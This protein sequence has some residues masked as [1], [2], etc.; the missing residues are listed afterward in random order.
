MY[1]SKIT[2]LCDERMTKFTNRC[3][4]RERLNSRLW[5]CW[6]RANKNIFSRRLKAASVELKLRTGSG[7]L[8]H[9][10]GQAM[11]KARRPYTHTHTHTQ[12]P[13]LR[14]RTWVR[15]G[16]HFSTFWIAFV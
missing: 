7:R 2:K 8:F 3:V 4:L 16:R 9:A 5:V 14:S 1:Y 11:A 6:Y 12:W 13:A 15:A 10:D